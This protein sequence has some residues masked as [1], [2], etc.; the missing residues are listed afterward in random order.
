MF[1]HLPTDSTPPVAPPSRRT[2][3]DLAYDAAV[4]TVVGVVMLYTYRRRL[5]RAIRDLAE[6][7]IMALVLFLAINA[8]SQRIR[9]DSVSMQPTLFAGDFVLV[10]KLAYRFGSPARG[11][12][13]VFKY[14]PDPTQIPYI[15]RIIGLPGDHIHISDGKV[16][17][18]GQLLLE[19]YL[20]VSTNRGG[21]WTVPANSI[22]VMGD[23]RNNSSD[24]RSWGFVPIENIIGKAEFIYLPFDHWAWL[25]FPS[26]IAAGPD[27]ALP[28]PTVTAP[29]NEV[30]AYPTPQDSLPTEAPHLEGSPTPYP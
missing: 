5:L 7:V 3:R 8:V 18:N 6:T 28:Q 14:P 22:F 15:K 26:A 29:P 19:P 11:D 30:I 21:D 16:Y 20:K 10:N 9:V 1:D 17:I 23:N 13:V 27:N 4:S 24:S 12:V 2:L 25:S